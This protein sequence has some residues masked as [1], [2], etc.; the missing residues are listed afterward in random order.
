M[1][2]VVVLDKAVLFTKFDGKTFIFNPKIENIGNYSIKIVLK[3]NNKYPLENRINFDV[4]II[5]SSECLSNQLP[6]TTSTI[7]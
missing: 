7:T 1:P 4:N 3:D 5:N 2:V 6:L